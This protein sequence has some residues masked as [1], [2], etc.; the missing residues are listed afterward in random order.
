MTRDPEEIEGAALLQVY[1]PMLKR[2]QKLYHSF[3]RDLKSRGMLTATLSPLEHVGMLFVHKSN[4]GLRLILD[5]RRSNAH[6][7]TS[8]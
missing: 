6:F 1:E 4:G 2:N 5:A 3:L 8:S 7:L